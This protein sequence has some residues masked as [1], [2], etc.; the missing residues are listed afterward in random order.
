MNPIHL[1]VEGSVEIVVSATEDAFEPRAR[2]C[3]QEIADKLGLGPERCAGAN[4]VKARLPRHKLERVKA[5][6]EANVSRRLHV[7]HLAAVAH[8]S[9]FHFTR[10][11]KQATGLSPHAYLTF[12]R[13]E[14]AKRM[15]AE[16]S[17][18][19]VEVAAQVGFQ[20]QGHFTEVFRRHAGTTPRRFR[21]GAHGV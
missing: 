4:V 17:L 19:L 6:I 8:L 20:T 15:L 18:A 3:A 10:L 16:S 5:F 11:F 2:L 21:L 12:H 13:I 9:P 1:S 14:R 7:E